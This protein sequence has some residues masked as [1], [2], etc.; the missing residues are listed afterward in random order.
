M[1]SSG[2]CTGMHGVLSLLAARGG[3]LVVTSLPL[4]SF[5]MESQHE[6][7]FRTLQNGLNLGKVVVRVAQ[8]REV[9]DGCHIMTG[10]TGGLGLLT[11]RWLGQCGARRLLLAS[12]GGALAQGTAAEWDAVRASCPQLAGV[13]DVA[14]NIALRRLKRITVDR[15]HVTNLPR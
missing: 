10:G 6:L 3:A 11:G 4:R 12:R 15:H 9:S 2:H 1:A 7:A 14:L 8:R 5:A 13:G